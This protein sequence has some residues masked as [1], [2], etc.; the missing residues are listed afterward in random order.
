MHSTT[1]NLSRELLDWYKKEKRSLE[2]RHTSDPYKIW[3]SEIMLQQTKVNTM[4]PY[5]NKWI[6]KYPDV[7]SVA[8]SK[9]DDLIK[10]WKGMG[11]Y[12]RCVNIY[13][14]AKIIMLKH[15]GKIPNN[16]KDIISLPGIGIYTAG[17]VLSIAY[18]KPYPAIDGNV[19][20]V[21]S[22]IL[23]IKNLTKKN[24]KRIE[25][26]ILLLI[27]KFNPG[28]FNQAIMELGAI[29]CKVKN[30]HCYSCP[31][32]NYCKAKKISKP[33]LYPKNKINKKIPHYNIAVGMIWCGNYFYIQ[34]R[35]QNKM[36]GGLWEFPGGKVKQNETIKKALKRTIKK[37]CDI[38]PIINKKIAQIKHTYSHFSITLHCYKCGLKNKNLLKTKN[39]NWITSQD[40]FK[41]P[42]PKANHKIFQVLNDN[43]W[44][45]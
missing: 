1:K 31:L 9:I 43:K 7:K 14:T 34:K 27:D 20:R 19:K 42:F 38:L 22:R 37:E 24:L 12:G 5:Y 40:I 28:D 35:P 16:Y 8:D 21:F 10:C 13:K 32:Q 3:I 26:N 33:N 6:D 18:N 41:F 44:I 11:Y 25:N 39:S 23:G 29:K 17:A 4:I 45:I 15:H 2:F 36:L 30:P